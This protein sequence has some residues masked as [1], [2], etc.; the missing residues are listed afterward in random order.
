MPEPDQKQILKHILSNL[1]V[2]GIAEDL[3]KKKYETFVPTIKRYN[4]ITTKNGVDT[5]VK[6]LRRLRN[7]VYKERSPGVSSIPSTRNT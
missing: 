2:H 7:L 5:E 6:E 1:R 3:V 4:K